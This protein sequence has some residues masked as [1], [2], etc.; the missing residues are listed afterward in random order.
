MG[1]VMKFFAVIGRFYTT[2][3]KSD[4]FVSI[5]EFWRAE[6]MLRLSQQDYERAI[7]MLNARMLVRE[8]AREHRHSVDRLL[9]R[10]VQNDNDDGLHCGGQRELRSIRQISEL[11]PRRP[12]RNS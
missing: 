10:D 5:H 9:G 6:I 2:V 8:V 3:T 7:G 12:W 4:S 11:F 1:R